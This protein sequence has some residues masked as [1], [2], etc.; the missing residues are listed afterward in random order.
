MAVYLSILL[1][2]FWCYFEQ[3]RTFSSRHFI[4][5]MISVRVSESSARIFQLGRFKVSVQF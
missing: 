4:D 2:D 3:S 1:H 5:F